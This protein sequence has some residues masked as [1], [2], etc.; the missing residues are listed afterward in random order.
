MNVNFIDRP[1]SCDRNCC[2]CLVNDN[3]VFINHENSKHEPIHRSCIQRWLN[4]GKPTCPLCKIPIKNRLTSPIRSIEH[5]VFEGHK[6]ATAGAETVSSSFIFGAFAAATC[7]ALILFGQWAARDTLAVSGGGYGMAYIAGIFARFIGDG[8]SAQSR[9]DVMAPIAAGTGVLVSLLPLW[10]RATQQ[11]YLFQGIA[12]YRFSQSAGFVRTGVSAGLGLATAAATRYFFQPDT[13]E[14]TLTT[15]TGSLGTLVSGID[16][17]KWINIV[18]ALAG[19]SASYCMYE[20]YG[21]IYS[22][23]TGCATS[24]IA[25]SIFRQAY[26]DKRRVG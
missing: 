23:I 22:A 9:I 14:K 5:T 6:A 24:G 12:L 15:L 10:T 2:I 19:M 17:N 26:G 25:A 21:P 11:A 4:E 8:V 7:A 3:D 1:V 18:P 20:E 13:W 16:S